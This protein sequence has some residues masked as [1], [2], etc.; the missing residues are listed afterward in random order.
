M[1]FCSKLVPLQAPLC[2]HVPKRSSCKFHGFLASK[3][4]FMPAFLS[5]VGRTRPVRAFLSDRP[6]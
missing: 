3:S 5:A 6:G 2:R 1:T 4:K